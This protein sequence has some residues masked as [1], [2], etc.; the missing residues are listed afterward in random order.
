MMARE[1]N[2]ADEMI[3]H[4]RSSIQILVVLALDFAF[5]PPSFL[6]NECLCTF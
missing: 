3:S 5:L 6:K 2:E 1:E 4:G